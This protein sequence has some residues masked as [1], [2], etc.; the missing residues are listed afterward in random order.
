MPNRDPPD[1]NGSPTSEIWETEGGGGVLCTNTVKANFTSGMDQ[2]KEMKPCTRENGND[3]TMDKTDS[4]PN[5]TKERMEFSEHI[6]A[7]VNNNRT[8]A[9]FNSDEEGEIDLSQLPP[10]AYSGIHES[11]INGRKGICEKWRYDSALDISDESGTSVRLHTNMPNEEELILLSPKHR[12]RVVRQLSPAALYSGVLSSSSREEEA[13][14]LK[15]HNGSEQNTYHSKPSISDPLTGHLLER[16]NHQATEMDIHFTARHTDNNIFCQEDLLVSSEASLDTKSASEDGLRSVPITQKTL[17]FGTDGSHH[18]SLEHSDNVSDHHEASLGEVQSQRQVTH[19]REVVHDDKVDIASLPILK[20]PLQKAGRHT[21]IRGRLSDDHPF[22][23]GAYNLGF[24]LASRDNCDRTGTRNEPECRKLFAEDLRMFLK[25]IGN[26]PFKVPVIGGGDLDLFLLAREVMLLGG[27]QNVVRKRAFRIVAQQLGIPKTCTSAASV[28]K[29]AYE[30][31]LFHY[32]QRIV[33]GKWPENP[34]KAVNMKER[35][36]EE[37]VKERKTRACMQVRSRSK[38]CRSIRHH[39][40]SESRI[41]NDLI[42]F[43]KGQSEGLSNSDR[44]ARL[45]LEGDPQDPF[46]LPCWANSIYQEHNFFAIIAETQTME[47]ANSKISQSR[48]I[49][50]VATRAVEQL[51]RY[52]VQDLK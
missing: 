49:F 36:F 13:E 41:N 42:I 15:K 18:T 33:F 19:S 45:A 52:L 22:S 11:H 50:N 4:I 46:T 35:V 20:N 48:L 28:L 10:T 3:S 24:K 12:Q 43:F 21:V 31:L 26:G 37:K 34:S 51:L 47:L 25:E 14:T 7:S 44:L 17:H 5:Q 16:P 32:E 8:D 6:K 2:S 40:L 9:F 39:H 38:G 23:I 29:G 27:V 30:R 1:R